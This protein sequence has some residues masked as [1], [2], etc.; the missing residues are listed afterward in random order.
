MSTSTS[1][2]STATSAPPKKSYPLALS[3]RNLPYFPAQVD[4]HIDVVVVDGD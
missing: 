1:L 2:S 3:E 4:E